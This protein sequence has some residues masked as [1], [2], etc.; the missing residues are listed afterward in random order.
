MKAAVRLWFLSALLACLAGAQGVAAVAI[1]DEVPRVSPTSFVGQWREHWGI[2]GETDV[3]YHDQYRVSQDES[4][5]IQVII[6]DRKQTI[7]DV[8][9]DRD[10]LTFTQHTDRYVVKYSLTIRPDHKWLIGTATTPK[11][12]VPVKW[13]RTK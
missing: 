4:G 1:E 8:R 13:E 6:L 7:K 12:V 9:V 3:T 10:T 2:P 11:K 5:A